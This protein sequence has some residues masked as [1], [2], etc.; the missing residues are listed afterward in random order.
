M[1]NAKS[2]IYL[3]LLMTLSANAQEKL[4]YYG[5]VDPVCFPTVDSIKFVPFIFD[6]LGTYDGVLIFS[7]A[8]SQLPVHSSDSLINFLQQGGKLYIGC[9]NWPLQAE[10]NQITTLLF[11]KQFWGNEQLSTHQKEDLSLGNSVVTFPL[12]HR[13]EVVTWIEDEPLV[14]S[15]NHFGGTLVLDGG[16]SKFYCNNSH[17]L[18]NWQFLLK[19]LID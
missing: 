8:N 1:K 12:D 11:N 15:T 13:L 14:L 18:N 2:I 3:F 6:S 5:N 17:Y 7:S 19:L 4:A 16:Y 9:E 10:G